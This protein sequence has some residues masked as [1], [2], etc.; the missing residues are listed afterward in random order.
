MRYLHPLGML[1]YNL[2]VAHPYLESEEKFPEAL[3]V[4]DFGDNYSQGAYQSMCFKP[5]LDLETEP[6]VKFEHVKSHQKAHWIPGPSGCLA[7]PPKEPKIMAQYP[8]T[9][10]IV[11]IGSIILEV[12]V[13]VPQ[14]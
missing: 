4:G 11:S 12:Q 2:Q 14:I 3:P 8:K 9:E 6:S 5:A 7:G 10:G 1:P 13:A